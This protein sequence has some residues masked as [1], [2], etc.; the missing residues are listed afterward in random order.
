[1]HRTEDTVGVH[2]PSTKMDT[3]MMREQ[4]L[5]YQ[6]EEEV[7]AEAVQTEPDLVPQEIIEGSPTVMAKSLVEVLIN[8]VS[9]KID[10]LCKVKNKG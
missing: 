9:T 2:R 4:A 10:L 7:E 6:V 5:E 3:V 8:L 1:M